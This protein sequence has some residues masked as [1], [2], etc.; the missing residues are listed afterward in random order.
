MHSYHP[1]IE[2]FFIAIKSKKQLRRV[3]EFFFK[4]DDSLDYIENIE[5]SLKGLDN[6]LK[7]KSW[8]SHYT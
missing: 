3:P 8:I 1:T 2:S 4:L 7:P 6:P 5:R